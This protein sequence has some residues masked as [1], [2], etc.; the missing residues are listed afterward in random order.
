MSEVGSLTNEAADIK[1]LLDADDDLLAVHSDPFSRPRM[2]PMDDIA[3]VRK[4]LRDDTNMKRWI[5]K[6]TEEGHEDEQ[7]IKQALAA[8]MNHIEREENKWDCE[9]ILSKDTA[10]EIMHYSYSLY[11]HS[12]IFE[13]LQPSQTTTPNQIKS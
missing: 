11:T 12:N 9:T 8:D 1:G 7:P 5:R 2:D 13:Y 4:G 10:S 3:H 6:Y